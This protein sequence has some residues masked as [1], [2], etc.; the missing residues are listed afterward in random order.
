MNDQRETKKITTPS[1]KEVELKTYL[2]ARERN[3]IKDVFSNGMKIDLSKIDPITK[4][5]VITEVSGN[6]LVKST[7]KLLE[8]VVVGFDGSN[9][10]VMDRILDG[11][12]KDYD[13]ILEKVNEV[14]DGNLELAE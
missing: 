4:K 11:S 7:E 5:P 10:N 12:P 3:M 1:G 14:N 2:T 9:E 13:Y 6:L 8:I